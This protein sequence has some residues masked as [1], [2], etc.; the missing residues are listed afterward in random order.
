MADCAELWEGSMLTVEEATSVPVEEA[1]SVVPEETASVV[2]A[3]SVVV[4]TAAVDEESDWAL[5][6]AA[7]M[8]ATTTEKRI[9]TGGL[10]TTRE[11]DN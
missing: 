2:V 3:T 6:A 9:L 8:P 1:A 5:T 4:E 11:E 10:C 7:K